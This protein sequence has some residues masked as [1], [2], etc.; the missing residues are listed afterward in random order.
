MNHFISLLWG[1]KFRI[2]FRTTLLGL[3]RKVLSCYP[4]PPELILT[5][6]MS[7]F[8]IVYLCIFEISFFPYSS[9]MSACLVV[10]INRVALLFVTLHIVG[11][12]I[13]DVFLQDVYFIVILCA[14][15]HDVY[16]YLFFL[17]VVN[18]TSILLESSILSSP[19]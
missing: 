16:F 17:C 3:F 15:I 13:L 18:H 14:V 9:S 12:S 4:V 5:K 11:K 10:S 7:C 1:Q 19:P 2:Y 8:R 6:K